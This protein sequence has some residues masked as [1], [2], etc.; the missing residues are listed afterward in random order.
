MQSLYLH[1]VCNLLE[2]I[3]ILKNTKIRIGDCN[4]IFEDNKTV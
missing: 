2:V 4:T 1:C 3:D